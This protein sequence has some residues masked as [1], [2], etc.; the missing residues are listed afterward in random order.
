MNKKIQEAINPSDGISLEC[1]SNGEIFRVKDRVM[2]LKNRPYAMNGDIGTITS[3]RNSTVDGITSVIIT[4]LFDGMNKTVDYA[5]GSFD[6]L[7]LAYATTIHK[8]QGSEYEKV[9]AIEERYP[10]D[11]VEHARWLYTAVTRASEKLVLVR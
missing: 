4:V 3:I 11:K 9:L 5:T 8:S 6:E 7:C 10:F 2:Q 1:N